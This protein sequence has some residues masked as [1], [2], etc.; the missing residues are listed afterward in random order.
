VQ[1]KGLCIALTYNSGM[2]PSDVVRPA[3]QAPAQVSTPASTPAS[4]LVPALALLLFTLL[5]SLAAA[6]A[7]PRIDGSVE[8]RI[9]RIRID[10]RALTVEELRHCGETQSIVVTPRELPAY[11]IQTSD[12]ARSRQFARD[13]LSEAKGARVWNLIRF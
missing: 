12:G 8:R 7:A 9:E 3:L 6:Q 10:D 4:A 13:G 5:P 11:E 2:R 1:I